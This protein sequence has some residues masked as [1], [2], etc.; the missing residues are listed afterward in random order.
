[1]LK[2]SRIEDMLAKGAMCHLNVETDQPQDESTS[3]RPQGGKR[4]PKNIMI[5]I[6]KVDPPVQK[7]SDLFA[8]LTLD[9]LVV[10]CLIGTGNCSEVVLA[11]NKCALDAHVT[12]SRPVSLADVVA[13]KVLQKDRISKAHKSAIIA[14]LRVFELLKEEPHPFLARMVT[15]SESKTRLWMGVEFYPGGDLRSMLARTG[16]FSEAQ[17]C[18]YTMEIALALAHLHS[19]NVLYGDVK[20]ENVAIAADG[21]IKLIDF[22]L[23]VIFEEE[24]HF[25]ERRGRMEIVTHSGT[26]GYCAPEVLWR[27]PHSF[28]SDWWSLGVLVHEIATGFLPW[29]DEDPLELT[30][31]ICSTSFRNRHGIES[32]SLLDFVSQLLDKDVEARLGYGGWNEVFNHRFLAELD[33]RA[34]LD[35]LLRPPVVPILA[36]AMDVS[37]FSPYFTERSL[38]Y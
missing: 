19:L 7:Q 20:P 36:N 30:Y 23:S 38:D 6:P 22:G 26:V 28:E 37:N 3:P 35:R 34:T 33:T 25:N 12:S 16:G 4:R 1:M 14:E 2:S 21:H 10:K 8:N 31:M 32:E 27:R 18:I 15:F 24:V 29:D 11:V 13:L 9:K 17:V 5:E